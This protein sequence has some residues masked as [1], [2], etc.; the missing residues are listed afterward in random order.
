MPSVGFSMLMAL[1]LRRLPAG[2]PAACLRERF[3]R[4]AQSLPPLQPASQQAGREAGE[5]SVVLRLRAAG[6][7]RLLGQPALQVGLVLVLACALGLS[8]TSQNIYYADHTAYYLHSSG[9]APNNDAIKTNLAGLLSEGGHY[10]EA[11]RIYE[12]I[13][14][15]NPDAGFVNYDL[16]YTYYRMGKLEEA[17]Y[18]LTRA[19]QLWPNWAS[20]Y[21][22]LGLT[23]FSMGHF[24]D[25]ALNLRRALSITPYADNYHFALGRVLKM[26]GN[27]PGA[28]AEFRAELALN[29]GH[30]EAR[31]QI[32]EIEN[33]LRP[34]QTPA[35][36]PQSLPYQEPALIPPSREKGEDSGVAR[37]PAASTEP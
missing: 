29:P 37:R 10:P 28:L 9:G 34:G 32:V 23:Q 18:Y 8:T 13:L 20:T 12:Q 3:G 33:A 11:A 35:T 36:T 7:A 31:Q 16:G 5:S 4:Q 15:R 25:A 17:E 21:F 19:T 27:L 14:V 1:A 30:A 26:R 22:Y 24:E 2:R 6:R